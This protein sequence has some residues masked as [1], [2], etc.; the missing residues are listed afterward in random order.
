[1]TAKTLN[2]PQPVAPAALRGR[3]V[4]VHIWDYTCINARDADG[5][6]VLVVDKPRLYAITRNPDARPHTLRLE[7]T[8]RGLALFS[9]SFTTCVRP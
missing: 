5:Q 2:T 8:A 9:F 4:L 3:A 7:A 6:A 1:M